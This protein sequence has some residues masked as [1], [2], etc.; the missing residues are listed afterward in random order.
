MT[1]E[2]D[3]RVLLRTAA[4]AVVPAGDGLS[5]IR[6]RIARK[7]R[8][9]VFALPATGALA[10]GIAAALFLNGGG[11]A[12]KLVVAPLGPSATPSAETSSTPGPATPYAGQ[13]L[14]DF[15]SSN[16]DEVVRRWLVQVGVQ[17]APE[18]HT[19]E[20]CDVVGIAVAGKHVGNAVLSRSFADGGI[21]YH[22]VGVTAAGMD[23][24]APKDGEAITSPTTVTGTLDQGVDESVLLRLVSQQGAPL[25]QTSAPAG[26]AAPWSAQLSWHST[27]WSSGV[28]VATTASAKDGAVTRLAAVPVN[29][30]SAPTS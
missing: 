11:G 2:D 28:L 5:L 29:R 13:A 8:L 16:K 1:A 4:D 12:D 19:C 27:D 15:F 22:L 17:G 10:L 18:N 23:I 6:Q 14:F 21:V 30:A 3:L 24:T 9:R 26:S 25:G 20:S 7:R